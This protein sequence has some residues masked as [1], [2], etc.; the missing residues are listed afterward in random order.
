MNQDSDSKK[1]TLEI[2]NEAVFVS[3]DDSHRLLTLE[4]NK[5]KYY[6]QK[7]YLYRLISL[8]GYF[9]ASIGFLLLVVATLDLDYKT[10]L[11]L[12][13]LYVGLII[14]II[15]F[16]LSST[17]KAKT[18]LS[19]SA[20]FPDLDM[21]ATWM[22]F[23]K[24]VKESYAE[25][26]SQTNE[27]KNIRQVISETLSNIDAKSYDR[28]LINQALSI[29]NSLVHGEDPKISNTEMRII[30]RRLSEITH[31]IRTKP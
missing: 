3:L 26:G 12:F 17:T 4:Q 21:I 24:A 31:Q 2:S 6:E 19:N 10:T 25:L 29:R 1:D 23:E 5:I 22:D 11:A 28:V 14:S 8:G 27:N 30:A 18:K 20:D 7:S 9:T 15:G 16:F 13:I